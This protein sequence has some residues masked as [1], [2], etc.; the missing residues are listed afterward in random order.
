MT[1]LDPNVDGYG[2]IYDGIEK[3]FPNPLTIGW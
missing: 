1:K 2:A 3:D